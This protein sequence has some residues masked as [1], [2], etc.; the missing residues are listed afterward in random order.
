MNKFFSEEKNLLAL[1]FVGEACKYDVK[2]E[3]R[4][5]FGVVLLIIANNAADFDA[6]CE[7]FIEDMRGLYF[8]QMERVKDPADSIAWSL[9]CGAT[10]RILAEYNLSVP[11]NLNHDILSFMRLMEG[12]YGQQDQY[13]FQNV[14]YSRNSLPVVILKRLLH[15]KYYGSLRDV[16]LSAQQATEKIENWETQLGE[17]EKRIIALK[18]NLEKIETGYNFVGLH[19]GFK[20]LEDKISG[21][22]FWTKIVMFF[23][24]FFA[25]APGIA[26]VCIAQSLDP[27]VAAVTN[28][29]FVLSILGSITLTI[30]FLY[31]FRIALREADACRAQ[32]VQIR[33]RMTLCQ[34][35]ESY[36]D[37]SKKLK[38]ANVDALSKFESLIF[39]GIVNTDDKLPSTFDG[40]DQLSAL[41]KTATGKN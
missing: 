24:G 26:E 11:G 32:L 22:L 5:L 8:D 10:Y 30:L 27:K 20:G 37:F 40:V 41:L 38:E 6:K 35:I 1:K 14:E 34:F 25:L 19:D 31:F 13:I 15:S 18:G 16:T 33:L 28:P 12:E 29:Q 3:A 17:M 23:F 39:S 21:Q 9:A 4:Y 2:N 36:A 7:V